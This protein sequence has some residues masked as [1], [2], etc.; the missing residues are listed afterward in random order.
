MDDS[1]WGHYTSWLMRVF[2]QFYIEMIV[3]IA[4]IFKD[5]FKLNSMGIRCK[6]YKDGNDYFI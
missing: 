1:A 6:Q 4:D 5:D 2:N 3:I